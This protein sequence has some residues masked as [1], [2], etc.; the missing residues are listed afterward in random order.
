[1]AN[2]A[3][4]DSIAFTNKATSTKLKEIK[5][6]DGANAKDVKI[7][8]LDESLIE[9]GPTAI[10]RKPLEVK[11]LCSYKWENG[12]SYAYTVFNELT[13]YD[14]TK[15][16]ASELL[17]LPY[18]TKLWVTDEAALT[19]DADAQTAEKKP[20]YGSDKTLR[21]K[22]LHIDYSD[23]AEDCKIN[24]NP[25]LSFFDKGY[26]ADIT[27]TYECLTNTKIDGSD[28]LGYIASIMIGDTD[29][30]YYDGSAADK[31][32]KVESNI[33]ISIEYKVRYREYR[34][35]V[36]NENSQEICSDNFFELYGGQDAK[37]TLRNPLQKQD[38]I[39]T[40]NNSLIGEY[41]IPEGSHTIKTQT[42]LSGTFTN[43][44]KTLTKSD[45]DFGYYV[46]KNTFNDTSENPIYIGSSQIIAY[47]DASDKFYI[48]CNSSNL[49]RLYNI[50]LFGCTGFTDY[51]GVMVGGGDQNAIVYNIPAKAICSIRKNSTIAQ[52]ENWRFN[53]SWGNDLSEN[54][55]INIIRAAQPNVFT[56]SFNNSYTNPSEFKNVVSSPDTLNPVGNIGTIKSEKY[57]LKFTAGC[58]TASDWKFALS[59]DT[60]YEYRVSSTQTVEGFTGTNGNYPGG[61][62]GMKVPGLTTDGFVPKYSYIA[63]TDYFP[64][65]PATYT[66]Y[67][68]LNSKDSS[69]AYQ[70]PAAELTRNST[71]YGKAYINRIALTFEENRLWLDY[72]VVNRTNANLKLTPRLIKDTYIYISKF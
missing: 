65:T 14:E 15:P 8:K 52:F 10:W 20:Y 58:D 55:F 64:L 33:T 3:I 44:V 57:E 24:G 48:K 2:N 66:G 46:I 5:Y 70:N 1:M 19:D 18:G 49:D 69:G 38:L 32:Y 13:G 40:G 54:K 36:I 31:Y 72:T 30:S 35:A 47:D 45:A 26:K 4:T 16:K 59:N 6:A 56:L 29:L 68:Y 51:D 62:I 43:N 12:K 28:K 60:D 50:E 22:I 11:L 27:G 41:I 63:I 67:L 71:V 39:A 42:S 34:V 25:P 37:L 21:S 23:V 53:V 9:G 61:Y 7:L 17:T